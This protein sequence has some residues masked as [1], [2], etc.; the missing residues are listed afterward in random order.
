MS[1]HPELNV[2]DSGSSQGA[3]YQ[4]AAETTVKRQ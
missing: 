1:L 2:G 4:S 3:D